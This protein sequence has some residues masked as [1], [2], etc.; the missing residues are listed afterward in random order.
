[1]PIAL[2][3]TAASQLEIRYKISGN[4]SRN[5]KYYHAALLSYQALIKVS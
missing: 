4:Q 2:T 1:L 3:D 5:E